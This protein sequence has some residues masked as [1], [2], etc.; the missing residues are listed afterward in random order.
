MG[1]EEQLGAIGNE[2]WEGGVWPSTRCT[3][4]AQSFPWAEQGELIPLAL[5]R[6]PPSGSVLSPLYP[7]VTVAWQSH[8]LIWG[9]AHHRGRF[10]LSCF[11]NKI[12]RNP[13]YIFDPLPLLL[14]LRERPRCP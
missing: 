10:S 14:G 13:F 8:S 4:L 7:W 6:L 1:K 3:S 11:D 2:N 9:F 5:P 12:E